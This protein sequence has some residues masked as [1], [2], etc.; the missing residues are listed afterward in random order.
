MACSDGRVLRPGVV[1]RVADM[2]SM[3]AMILQL[4]RDVFSPCPACDVHSDTKSCHEH[5]RTTAVIC[6][7]FRS[8][9]HHSF[10]HDLGGTGEVSQ[11]VV[12]DVF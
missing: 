5:G 4:A 2:G 11:A 7:I 3:R 9:G 1:D 8:C 12:H 6:Q 10:D